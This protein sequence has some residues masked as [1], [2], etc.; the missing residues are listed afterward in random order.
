LAI[1][2]T[3]FICEHFRP[4]S[5]EVFIYLGSFVECMIYTV[6]ACSVIALRRRRPEEGRPYRIPGGL[7][8]PIVVAVFFGLLM[9]A[10]VVEKPVVG[11][12]VLTVG[13]AS[14]YYG[15]RVVPILRAQ[16][17]ESRAK[18]GRRRPGRRPPADTT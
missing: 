1:S 9:L 15:W 3:V 6:M 17:R 5:Y 16:A 18:R 11:I 14:A 8:V 10:I 13:S 2:I 4:E 12:V 7:L